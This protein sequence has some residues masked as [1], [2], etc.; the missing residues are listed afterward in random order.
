MAGN[1]IRGGYR[2]HLYRSG[3]FTLIELL[4]VMAV[5]SILLAVLV[6]SLARARGRSQRV[7]CQNNIRLFYIGQ[8]AYANDYDQRL[9]SSPADAAGEHMTFPPKT[10]PVVIG[11]PA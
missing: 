4:T 1:W 3:A 2:C 7:V 5:I 9:L 10:V 8:A 6:P 11:V